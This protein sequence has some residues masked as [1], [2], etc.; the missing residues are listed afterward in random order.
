ML[1]VK[2]F[3][4]NLDHKT[5]AALHPQINIMYPTDRS[6]TCSDHPSTEKSSTTRITSPPVVPLVLPAQ[7]VSAQQSTTKTVSTIT[8][9]QQ[10][11]QA[12][13]KLSSQ[14]KRLVHNE[15]LKFKMNQ[16]ER[17]HGK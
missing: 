8:L 13:D 14:Y 6:S 16:Y 3:R 15:V 7:Q 1:Q 17:S 4:K 10:R 11:T 12:L 2:R 5:D 9:L